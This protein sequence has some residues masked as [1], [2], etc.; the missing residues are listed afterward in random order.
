MHSPV[1]FET[2]NDVVYKAALKRP[3]L[4]MVEHRMKTTNYTNK[5]QF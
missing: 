5:L 1:L 2:N 4:M 3:M